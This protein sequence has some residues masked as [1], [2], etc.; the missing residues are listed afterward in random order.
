MPWKWFRDRRPT[1]PLPRRSRRPTL[2]A[3]EDRRLL[4]TVWTVTNTADHGPGSLRDA[5]ARAQPGDAVVFDTRGAFASP[6]TIALQSTLV[7]DKSLIIAGPGANNLTIDGVHAPGTTEGAAVIQVQDVLDVNGAVARQADVA[8]SGLTLAHGDRGVFNRDFA[9]L[10]LS[11]CTVSDN[12]NLQTGDEFGAGICNCLAST[13]TAS[14]CLITRNYAGTGGGGIDNSGSMA[15]SD[16]QVSGNGAGLVGGGIYGD[17]WMALSGCQ[18]SGNTAGGGGGICCVNGQVTLSGC[19]VSGNAASGDGG[20]ILNL[21]QARATLSGCQVSGNTASF[22][23]GGI[24]NVGDSYT[25]ILSLTSSTVSGNIAGQDGGGVYNDHGGSLS[26]SFSTLAL[27]HALQ[28]NGGGLCNLSAATLSYST[29]KQNA[30]HGDGGGVFNSGAYSDVLLQVAGCA[31]ASNQAA[32]GGGLFNAGAQATVENSTLAQ[33]SAGT[34]GGV[35]DFA[36]SLTL[37][38]DTVAGN[39]ASVVGGG[40]YDPPD[41]LGSLFPSGTFLHNTIV[42]RNFVSSTTSFPPGRSPSDVTGPIRSAGANLIQAPAGATVRPTK[43]GVHDLFG[44]DPRLGPLQDN[45][46]PTWTM[47]L[48]SGSPAIGAGE[49]AGPMTDQRGLTRLLY[50]GGHIDIGAFAVLTTGTPATPP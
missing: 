22:N 10:S 23:G 25:A 11:N 42:A 14:H 17:G 12:S 18:V 4:S 26:V 5:V 31:L 40:I 44:V 29:L 34:G 33:N 21:L 30:A 2:E 32:R 19:Q 43:A 45:G 24:C 35:C 3:L 38:S 20:G 47:A 27:N 41:A 15:L 28:G 46:G 48:L 50:P 1:K 9:Q 16:C 8:V 49:P 39:A 13:L 6:T 7:I 37:L 36:R